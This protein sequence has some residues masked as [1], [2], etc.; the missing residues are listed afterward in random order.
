MQHA[1]IPLLKLFRGRRKNIASPFIN[2]GRVSLEEFLRK[3]KDQEE[4][5]D[6]N[7]EDIREYFK[8][9]QFLISAA[10]D[11]LARGINE[12]T[13]ENSFAFYQ[14]EV[15]ISQTNVQLAGFMSPRGWCTAEAGSIVGVTVTISAARTAGSLIVEPTITDKDTGTITATGLTATL[16]GTNTRST[17]SQQDPGTD[18]FDGGDLIGLRIT[19][20]ADWAPTTANLDSCVWI[21]L[22]G[23]VR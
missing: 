2:Q 11:N 14:D 13:K 12:R 10:I 6:K 22:N 4:I 23:L 16:D 17:F 9:E 8:N 3:V 5:L 20:S 15:P 7:F 19:T 1:E 21:I 18:I